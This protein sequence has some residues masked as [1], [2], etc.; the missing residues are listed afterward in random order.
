MRIIE[1]GSFDPYWNLASEE[2]LME[3]ENDDV[4][5]LWRNQNT[6]VI[7]KNQN[8]W[9]EVNVPYTEEHQ[10]SVVRR[11]SGGGAVFHDLGNVNFTYITTAPPDRTI[12]FSR[13]TAPILQAL[14]E[15]GV[16]ATADGR[17]DLVVSGAKISGNAQ[18]VFRRADGSERLLHHGTLLFGADLSRLSG[19]LLVSPE[20][21]RSKGVASVR[22]R[23]TNLCDLPGFPA[24]S[25][26]A[27]MQHLLR[28]AEK[29]GDSFRIPFSKDEI[30]GID[31]LREKKYST[32]EWNFG[33]SMRHDASCQA[34]FPFGSVCADFTVKEGRICDLTLTGDYFGCAPV[35]VLEDALRGTL[36]RE[37]SLVQAMT[38][39]PAPVDEYISGAQAEDIAALLL[40]RLSPIHENHET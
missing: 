26:E 13:F 17:N 16:Q 23:V 38:S 11:M 37:D 25:V 36:L 34:R 28:C 4:F 20:K 3:H 6:V 10:I 12:D 31:V 29:Q 40:G 9:A 24:M 33:A 32:W 30:A 5:M 18:C 39:L 19:A 27:F 22:S 14:A 15:L 8:A 7:G 2:Y 21:I 1:N 35:S